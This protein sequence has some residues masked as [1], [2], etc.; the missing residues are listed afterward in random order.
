MPRFLE[1]E[2]AASSARF[3]A[4][5]YA[6]LLARAAQRGADR[7]LV[8]GAD[9]LDAGRSGGST[10]RSARWMEAALQHPLAKGVRRSLRRPG[11]AR[12]GGATPKTPTVRL[13]GCVRPRRELLQWRDHPGPMESGP[14]G[15]RLATNDSR[16]SSRVLIVAEVERRSPSTSAILLFTDTASLRPARS[17]KFV[18][19]HQPTP[20]RLRRTR[21]AA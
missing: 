7:A 21:S 3:T 15:I 6:E 2:E 5:C 13:P 10:K 19:R 20:A 11:R 4:F 17:M 9:G 12:R 1:F 16:S 18:G 8:S 14:N